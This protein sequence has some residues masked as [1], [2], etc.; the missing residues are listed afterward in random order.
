[1]ELFRIC[2]IIKEGRVWDIQFTKQKSETGRPRYREESVLSLVK[3]Y[4][5]EAV[6]GESDYNL[7]LYGGHNDLQMFND[8]W[9][10]DVLEGKW[11]EVEAL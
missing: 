2:V 7:M 4:N 8:L 6:E 5:Q 10:Y 3:S 11:L 9:I 1:M